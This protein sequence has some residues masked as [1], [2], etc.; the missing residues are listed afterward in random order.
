[1]NAGQIAE[2]VVNRLTAGGE[3]CLDIESTK[4]E[5][6]VHDAFLEACPWF[7]EPPRFVT[8]PVVPVAPPTGGDGTG[9]FVDLKDVD[10][11][12]YYIRRVHTVRSRYYHTGDIVRDLLLLPAAPL[13][14][15]SI[16]EHSAWQMTWPMV[17]DLLGRTLTYK[18]EEPENRLLVDDAQEGAVTLEYI[19]KITSVD[20]VTFKKALTW[21]TNMTEARTMEAVARVRGKFRG[22]FAVE[23]DASEMLST[24]Q[25]RVEKLQEE[26]KTLHFVSL[27]R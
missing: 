17:K 20:H 5:K 1:M 26:L 2:L 24:A 4:V 10:P 16:E 9:G 19:P 22:Q 3:V 18:H 25:A 6:F 12:V 21:I 11:P 13:E 23:T 15:E 7:D 27:A 14:T 8:L